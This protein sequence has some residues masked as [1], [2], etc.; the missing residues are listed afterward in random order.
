MKARTRMRPRVKARARMNLLHQFQHTLPNSSSSNVS[1]YLPL[2]LSLSLSLHTVRTWL[3]I[4]TGPIYGQNHP[5][6]N[7]NEIYHPTYIDG[8]S[9][10]CRPGFVSCHHQAHTHPYRRL[11]HALPSAPFLRH[12]MQRVL[13]YHLIKERRDVSRSK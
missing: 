4:R 11:L 6:H 3:C 10:R 12:S 7:A 8:S 2:S 5:E 9:L 13:R 1:L